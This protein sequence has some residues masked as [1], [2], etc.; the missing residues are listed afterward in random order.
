MRL[1]LG[2]IFIRDI[3]FG[4]V[5]EVKDA[6]LYINKE[7]IL[8]EIGGDEHIKSI[9]IELARPGESVRIIP[10]KDVIEPRVKVEGN[11]GIFPGIISKVE[12]IGSGRTHTLYGCAV[13]TTGKIV[14]FQEGIIDI[15]GPGAEYCPFSNLNNVVVIAEPVDGLKQQ[16]IYERLLEI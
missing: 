3:Q 8:K 7:E 6:T 14:G 2:K 5:T 16:H 4:E 1:E 11:G 15:T 13:V 10:V 12:T 9:D